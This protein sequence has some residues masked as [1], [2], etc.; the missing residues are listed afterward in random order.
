[1]RNYGL[2]AIVF[3]MMASGAA[4]PQQQVSSTAQSCFASGADGRPVLGWTG[5]PS[6]DAVSLAQELQEIVESQSTQLTGVSYCH[7]YRSI[8]VYASN[9]RG[10]GAQQVMD[11]AT[12]SP[13]VPVRLISVPYRSMISEPP[14]VASPTLHRALQSTLL[15]ASI[16][17]TAD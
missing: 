11:A 14:Q 13:S 12:N 4:I 17:T 1:M 10:S 3:G 16:C 2:V 5:D 6:P 7:D 9:I 8:Q 15:P